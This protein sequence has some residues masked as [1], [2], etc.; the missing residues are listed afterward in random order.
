MLN[1]N[2]TNLMSVVVL[3]AFAPVTRG[4][5]IQE[6]LSADRRAIVEPTVDGVVTE[7]TL[8]RRREV[9]FVHIVGPF[10]LMAATLVLV[11]FMNVVLWMVGS[12]GVPP[13]YPL[14][15]FAGAI[16][17]VGGLSIGLVSVLLIKPT[18]AWTQK[19]R[20]ARMKP[21]Q[22]S[23]YRPSR[24]SHPS[25]WDLLLALPVCYLVVSLSSGL[26]PWI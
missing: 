3:H 19:Q 18:A 26:W 25:N 2:I 1:H 13:P 4:N 12:A 15:I 16:L 23:H 9:I 8:E 7:D 6:A 22:Q 5:T 17:S 20:F 24:L 14:Q 11:L 10:F 21:A